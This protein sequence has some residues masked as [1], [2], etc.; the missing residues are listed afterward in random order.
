[1]IRPATK[2]GLEILGGA[3]A[4]LAVAG[5]AFAVL[6]ARGPVSLDM[7]A[8]S[9]S[10]LLSDT[11]EGYAVSVKHA[12]IAWSQAERALQLRV[13]D[14][15]VSD[16]DGTQVASVPELAIG[17]STAGLREG[18]FAP[19]RVRVIEA[20][21]DI[22]RDA[23]GRFSL[24]EDGAGQAESDN[25]G[26]MALILAWISNDRSAGGV[27]SYLNEIEIERARLVFTDERTGLRIAAP[28]ARLSLARTEDGVAGQLNAQAL[29]A[30]E[31]FDLALDIAYN[32]TGSKGRADASFS[33]VRISHLAKSSEVFDPFKVFDFPVSGVATLD[34]GPAGLIEQAQVSLS[35]EAG[36]IALPIDGAEPLP[37]DAASLNGT[38]YPRTGHLDIEWFNIEGEAVRADVSG[39]AQLVMAQ[40]A[41]LE[42]VSGWVNLTGS[43]IVLDLPALFDGPMEITDL[44]SAIEVSF[45]DPWRVDI[46][47]V[48]LDLDGADVALTGAIEAG[49][50]SPSIRLDGEVRDFEAANLGRYWPNG[51]V[52]P[53]RDWVVPHVHSGR[54]TRGVLRVSA[55]AKELTSKPLPENG[56]RF[57]FAIEDGVASYVT[58]LPPISNASAAMRLTGQTFTLD[59][60]KANILG[61]E[62]TSGKVLMNALGVKGT[63]IEITASGSGPVEDLLEIVDAEPLGFISE[64]GSSPS[65][66]AGTADLK[67]AMTIPQKSKIEVEDVVFTV[68]ADARDV[69]LPRFAEIALEDGDVELEVT[70]LGLSGSG[71]IKANGVPSQLEY[72]EKFRGRGATPSSYTLKASLGDG[73]RAALGFDTGD[74]L[75]GTVPVVLSAKGNGTKISEVVA[76]LDLSAAAIEI[77]QLEFSKPAGVSVRSHLEGRIADDGTVLISDVSLHGGGLAVSGSARL[78]PDWRLLSAD[79][80]SIQI[81]EFSNISAETGRTADGALTISIDGAYLNAAPL[82]KEGLRSSEGG[83]TSPWQFDARI[84]AVELRKGVVANTL[85]ARIESEGGALQFVDVSSELNGGGEFGAGLSQTRDGTRQLIVT[86][87]DAGRAVRGLTGVEAIDGGVLTLNLSLRDEV[88]DGEAPTAPVPPNGPEAD[89]AL[90]ARTQDADIS[91]N[92]TIDEFRVVD[93][94]VLARLLN[95][96]SL[97]GIGD[98]LQG[99]GIAFNTLEMSFS[100]SDGLLGIDSGRAAGPAIG[101]TVQGVVDQQ[102][103]VA[104]LRGSIVPAFAVNSALGYVPVVGELLVSRKGE[105]VFGFT[106]GVDGPLE[107]PQL[108]VNPL[109]ALAP[110]FL[111]RLFEMG[112]AEARRAPEADEVPAAQ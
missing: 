80:P 58:G 23:S 3:V 34:L 69:T 104:D 10:R 65:E 76:D 86:S 108:T 96:G 64:Y 66:F 41:P 43:D 11:D 35:G 1:M 37:M 9:L 105:G 77:P 60:E 72:T 2:H 85:A 28:E 54:L 102:R 103:E 14:V 7:F 110:G 36:F 87:D 22:H 26:A 55:T 107:D 106:Y 94:P 90:I 21:V 101:L 46:R 50:D 89:A 109:S 91:G 47:S 32:K 18:R 83:A 49:P 48:H 92:V 56:I 38:Y 97:Q 30:D 71:T 67:F 19:T 93:L 112:E 6:L 20:Q 98:L 39:Q 78:G 16:K 62:L 100:L 74:T 25:S 44:A 79:F 70:Q 31:V 53:A 68:N 99:E 52:Q 111:R 12:Q 33:S 81:P 15:G 5:V 82:L 13:S 40:T 27:S 95:I 84:A 4:V 17:L 42:A 51:V 59:L 8:P 63:P 61:T 29:V 57:D 88:P 73:E 45:A 75:V 24:G